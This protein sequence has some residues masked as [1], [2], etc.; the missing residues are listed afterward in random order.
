MLMLLL[1]A[2]IYHLEGEGDYRFAT[3]HWQYPTQLAGLNGFQVNYCEMQAWGP[4]RCRTKVCMQ[5]RSVVTCTSEGGDPALEKILLMYSELKVLTNTMFNTSV[6]GQHCLEL[7]S[8]SFR[9]LGFN[10]A[11]TTTVH[12]YQGTI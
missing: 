11:V 9:W 8:S 1:C 5:W 4:N 2:E 3:L 6:A 12:F 10:P 7:W